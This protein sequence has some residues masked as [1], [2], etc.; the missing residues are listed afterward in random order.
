MLVRVAAKSPESSRATLRR[1]AEHWKKIAA[2]ESGE[3]WR[4]ASAVSRQVWAW[5]KMSASLT[6]SQL[7]RVAVSENLRVL[8]LRAEL[9]WVL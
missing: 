8:W 6:V 7:L 9:G 2:L 3:A 1:F 5:R 4:W